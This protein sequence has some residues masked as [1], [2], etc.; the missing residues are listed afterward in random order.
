[1]QIIRFDNFSTIKNPAD[2]PLL[3]FRAASSVIRIHT[4]KH[5][6]HSIP[7]TAELLYL[8]AFDIDVFSARDGIHTSL[9]RFWALPPYGIDAESACVSER[10]ARLGS[11]L[12]YA[13][14][15]DAK[16]GRDDCAMDGSG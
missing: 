6:P 11:T 3:P 5:T 16:D 15:I 8:S 7:Q 1:M 10:T 2:L 14:A 9:L 12:T 13:D 4:S